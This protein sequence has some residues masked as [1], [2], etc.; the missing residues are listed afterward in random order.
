M[1]TRIIKTSF[2]KSMIRKKAPYHARNVYRYLLTCEHINISGEFE[3]SDEQIQLEMGIAK[4][5][6]QVAKKWLQDN[7]KVLFAD[8]YIKVIHA[9]EHNG[10][11]NSPKNEKAYQKELAYTPDSIRAVFDSLLD[12]TIDTSMDTNHKSEIK[13][14]GVQGETKPELSKEQVECLSF[15]EVWNHVF[16]TGY[17][18]VD[19]LL[20]NYKYWRGQYSV[21][22]IEQAIKTAHS[23]DFWRD[24]ITPEILLRRF[25]QNRERVNRIEEF[26]NHSVKSSDPY[27]GY[28]KV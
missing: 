19:A 6:L 2:S 20:D 22:Q 28:K 9:L 11:L 8:G 24:K 18:S 12:T 25:G 17:S 7:K 15:L 5:D 16:G 13:K 1:K 23:H 4:K 3:L 14:K 26:I 21:E 27:Y 10:Y